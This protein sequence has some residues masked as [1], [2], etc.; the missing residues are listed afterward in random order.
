DSGASGF[1]LLEDGDGED[2]SPAAR[3]LAPSGRG[4]DRQAG[5]NCE[6]Q[7]GRL[8]Q[9]FLTEGGTHEL[10]NAANS[11]VPEFVL[12]SLPVRSADIPVGRCRRFPPSRPELATQRTQ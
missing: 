6:D 9:N 8:K 3:P 1:V 11:S 5:G 2:R 10:R 4:A 12:E 7:L